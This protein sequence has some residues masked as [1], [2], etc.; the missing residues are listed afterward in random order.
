[1]GTTL[2]SHHAAEITYVFGNLIDRGGEPVDGRASPITEGEWTDVDRRVSAV[3]MDHWVQFAATGNPNRDGRSQWPEFDAADQHLTFG[4]TLE[5]GT[6]LHAAG[7]E[8][9][10]SY[11]IGRRTVDRSQ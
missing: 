4:D 8:L 5:V 9:Y 3:M 2:G 10:D 7:V 11:Q 6:G 1:M